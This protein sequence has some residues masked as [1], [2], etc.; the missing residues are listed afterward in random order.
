[1]YEDLLSFHKQNFFKNWYNIHIYIFV[2]F[3]IYSSKFANEIINNSERLL[4]FPTD[5]SHSFRYYLI[6]MKGAVYLFLIS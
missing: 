2:N 6:L 1:M 3:I 5:F 4:E